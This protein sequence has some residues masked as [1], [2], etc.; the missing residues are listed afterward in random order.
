MNRLLLSVLLLG[1]IAA[2]SSV[3]QEQKS[4]VVKKQPVSK[5]VD[6]S[7]TKPAKTQVVEK[8]TGPVEKLSCFTG[9][10]DRHA[11]IGVRLV[12]EKVDYFA[13]YSK[14][15]PRTCSIDVGRDG[16][17]GR[18]E[19]NGADSKITLAQHS[20]VLLIHRDHGSYRFDFRN[21]DRM[22]YCGM[23][24][25]INGSLTVRRGESKCTVVGIMK[26]H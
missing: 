1:L 9:V 5:A 21:V 8:L 7:A 15:R 26:G 10:T 11:R 12:G 24:G 20:G 4:A 18:W 16:H 2:C 6:H 14:R 13:F 17:N 23:E 25:E 22:K 19:D 3:P